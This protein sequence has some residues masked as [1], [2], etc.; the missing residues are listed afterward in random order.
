VKDRRAVLSLLVAVV[1][2]LIVW[3][4]QTG[5]E[6]QDSPAG[7]GAVVTTSAQPSQAPDVSGLP[8]V[9]VAELPSQARDTLRS[10]DAGGPFRYEQDGSVFGNF[11]G[12]LPSR[13]RGYYMEY[14]VVTPESPDRGA[15]RIVAGVD[16]DFYYTDDHYFSFSRIIR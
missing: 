11:E 2:A 9:E 8:R 12:H 7:P 14:T 5:G 13:P 16:S 15:R 6:A 4:A 10:I 3:S 1:T